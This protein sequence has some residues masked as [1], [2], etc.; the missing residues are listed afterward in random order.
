MPITSKTI[1]EAVSRYEREMLSWMQ[2]NHPQHLATIREQKAITDQLEP[3]LTQAL[4]EFNEQFVV[5][6][7]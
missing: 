7:A 6:E 3:Q 2:T 1:D 5:Q 4:R